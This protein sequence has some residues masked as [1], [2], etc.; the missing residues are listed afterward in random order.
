MVY[1]IRTADAEAPA[2]LGAG[3]WVPIPPD[4]GDVDVETFPTR[5][6][7]EAY[8]RE[9]ETRDDIRDAVKDMCRIIA[10]DAATAA[11]QR[12]AL[13]T[14]IDAMAPEILESLERK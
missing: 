10:D 4:G 8:A 5:P 3:G 6:I 11:E 7:A 14:L 12:A 13:L 1:L 2:I 9:R